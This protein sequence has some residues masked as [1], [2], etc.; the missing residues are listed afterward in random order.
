MVGGRFP[1]PEAVSLIEKAASAVVAVPSLTEM[2]IELNVPT[3]PDCGVPLKSPL[4][5]EKEAQGGRFTMP[6]VSKLPSASA[7]LGWK[8]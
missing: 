8:L 1:V 7:A 6:N 4:D 5:A 2:T 3:F